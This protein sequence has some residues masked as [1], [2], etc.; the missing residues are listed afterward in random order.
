MSI[1]KTNLEIEMKCYISEEQYKNLINHFNLNDKINVQIN[2][3]FDTDNFD[4][5]NN[6]IILRIR[7]KQNQYKITSKVPQSVG[8][9]ES[10]VYLTETDALNIL[11][12]GFDAN[13]INL[14][15]FVKKKCDLTTYRAS[16]NYKSGK[17][18]I[19]KSIYGN[20]TDYEVEF[21][22]ENEELGK[23]EFNEFLEL[24]GI[25]PTKTQSKAVRA[26]NELKK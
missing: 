15:Y 14:D 5:V 20:K 2:H 16:T 21:E 19:D 6:K 8:T 23:L 12:N 17:L 1:N 3:Y 25:T 4:L 13:I 26:L 11:D 22:V 24:F 10:H 9:L 7:Q 18:F